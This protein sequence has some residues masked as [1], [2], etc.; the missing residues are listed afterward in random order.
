[1]LHMAQSPKL[2][3]V[4]IIIVVV[5]ALAVVVT[6]FWSQ[7]TR[8]PVDGVPELQAP[9]TADNTPQVAP[10][11]GAES[12]DSETPGVKGQM[13]GSRETAGTAQPTRAGFD[14][15]ETVPR[16]V[17]LADYKAGLWAEVQAN[18]PKPRDLND[19]EV[20]ADLAYRLYTYYGNCSVIPRTEQQVDQRLEHI[21]KRV[22]QANGR[23]LQRME[24]HVDQTMS[25]YELCLLIP[26][27]VD[28][29][30]EAVHWLTK[31]VQ[32]GHDVAEIQFYDKAMGFI[33]RPDQFTNDPPLAM[34]QAGLVYGF[35][36]TARLGLARALEKG[37][38]EAYLAN[39]RAL[40][41]GLIYPKNPTEAFA[42]ARVAELTAARNHLILED[43]E[44]WKK[45]AAQHLTEEQLRLAENKALELQSRN[46]D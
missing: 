45:A 36:D 13:S 8:S 42:Y 2:K 7:S 31:A 20:D 27:E 37:H 3:P 19:P 12:G 26:P 10:V 34:Q 41:E 16:D 25:N 46:Q 17:A 21:A 44:Y 5:L 29:R 40:L 28:C 43:L 24:G 38:P 9:Q 33:L 1:M 18:P 14:E 4:F 22:E 6:Y 32:L 39:S 23:H 35:K 11:T 15:P 30:L